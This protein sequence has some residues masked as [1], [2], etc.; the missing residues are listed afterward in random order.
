[1][2]K[3]K[4]R[5]VSLILAMCMIITSIMPT[6]PVLAAA[7]KYYTIEKYDADGTGTMLVNPT[8]TSN[9]IGRYGTNFITSLLG[10][11]DNVKMSDDAVTGLPDASQDDGWLDNGD[12]G[13]GSKWI[14]ATDHYDEAY[15]DS[16]SF[17]ASDATTL[18]FIY[19]PGG[20]YEKAGLTTEGAD[21]ADAIV[22]V[23]KT[24]LIKVLSDYN[25]D[26]L[27]GNR[28]K[29][30]DD[31]IAMILNTTDATAES[32]EAAVDNMQSASDLADSITLP[33]ESMELYVGQKITLEPT[34]KPDGSTDKLTWESSNEE[35]VT[36]ED[37]VLKAM[38]DGIATVTVAAETEGLTDS[39]KVT[40]KPLQSFYISMQGTSNVIEAEKQA[41]TLMAFTGPSGIENLDYQW[42]VEDPSIAEVTP[43][44]GN[45][46]MA[47]VKG[48]AEGTTNV[49]VSLGSS[50]TEFEVKVTPYQGPYVYF[51]YT[52]PNKEDQLLDENNT[53]TLT[54]LDEGKFAVGNSDGGA[55]WSGGN[56]YVTSIQGGDDLQYWTF[57]NKETGV[58]NPWDVRKLNI[59]V[60]SGG[61]TKSFTVDCVSSG[62]TEPKAYV[63][64]QE[65][66]MDAPYVT[67]GTTSGVAVNTKGKNADDDWI[68]IPTQALH[69]DTSDTT[70]NFRW[71]GNQMSIAS[72]GQ[73][74]MS[75][76]M[77]DD[78]SVKTQFVAK[79]DYVPL[80]GFT[81]ETPETFK[82]TGE[83]DF[84]TGYYY[85]LQLYSDNLKITYE[86]SNATNTELNWESLTP[87]IA[88]FTTEHN[89]G[90]VPKKCGTAKFKI[91]RVFS[92]LS[93]IYGLSHPSTSM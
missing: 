21:W 43:M 2:T 32:V 20:D 88:F 23:P 1:M 90:I 48:K 16:T 33:E 75:V 3:I 12:L 58:W 39:V 67:Q 36:V 34:L 14:I 73:A 57:I 31:G 63:G 56:A 74:T 46:F 59:T 49:I 24:E 13:E 22:K 70:Y 55:T 27:G 29:A 69:Y 80:T 83:T 81:I 37:G 62:I 18:R 89:S 42:S 68:D 60:D 10:G 65:V 54:C 6:V 47:E 7:D 35:I 4:R 45:T 87:D 76:F 40:V 26:E 5:I 9:Y 30:Y 51:D 78:W 50:T 19:V 38:S 52:D 17:Y 79:C 41:L 86:P 64:D 77:K 93:I 72:G 92:Q 44:E 15:L 66:T 85:G 71:V 91:S 28:R 84:M 61:W 8:K 25:Q 53:I 82:I 11:S